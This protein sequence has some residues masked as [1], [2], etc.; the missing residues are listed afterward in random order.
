M[1]NASNTPTSKTN[2]AP[3]TGLPP[4]MKDPT[5]EPSI[6]K[7][8]TSSNNNAKKLFGMDYRSLATVAGLTGFFIIAMAGVV[9]SLRTRFGAQDFSPTAPDLSSADVEQV[10]DCSLTFNVAPPENEIVCDK[11]SYQDELANTAGNYQLLTERSNFQ[12]GQVIVFSFELTNNGESDAIITATDDLGELAPSGTTFSYTFLDSDCSGNAFNSTTEILT[13]TSQTLSP[14]ESERHSFRIRLGNTIANNLTLTNVVDISSTDTSNTNNGETITGSCEAEVTVTTTSV[15]PSPTPSPSVT[16]TPSVS[17]SPTP[18]VSPSPSPTPAPGCNERCVSNGDCSN[19]NHICYGDVCR[20][21]DY[22]TSA[23]CTPP[24]TPSPSPSPIVGCND[25]C[26]ENRDC[27]NS[28]HICQQG[29]CR[30]VDYPNSADC[31]PPQQVTNTPG[32]PQLPG[33]LP[34]TGADDFD[35]WIKAGLGVLA[36]G[37]LLLLLL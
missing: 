24:T 3:L 9:I 20:H 4:V 8:T 15:S 37:A 31:R 36:A 35:V 14:G 33:E 32:Q 12:P 30:D 28:D 5:M 19:N 29:R 10:A 26:V 16:P 1:I 13:C 34:R 11:T 23:T 2:E 21:V 27:A 22:P 17:P 18:S 6:P 7:A 25:V